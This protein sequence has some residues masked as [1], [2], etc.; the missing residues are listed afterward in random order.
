MVP[1]P[2]PR[3]VNVLGPAIRATTAQKVASRRLPR[4]VPLQRRPRS[5]PRCISAS[6]V[7]GRWSL[8]GTIRHQMTAMPSRGPGTMYVPLGRSAS[9][10]SSSCARKGCTERRGAC[11]PKTAR[12]R[13]TP[14]RTARKARF[15]PPNVPR[16]FTVPLEGNSSPAHLAR[17]V[18]PL[19][20]LIQG[21]MAFV[22]SATIAQQPLSRK[23]KWSAQLENSEIGRV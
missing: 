2:E 5:K 17:T 23:R 15:S 8:Q 7:F 18:V 12:P 1:K 10:A 13:A 4:L 16:D 22:Q 14:Q 21:V 11:R 19:D 3:L 6:M 20:S 9:L